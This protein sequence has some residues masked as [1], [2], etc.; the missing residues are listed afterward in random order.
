MVNLC[1]FTLHI[2]LNKWIMDKLSIVI[3]VYNEEQNVNPLYEQI[4]ESLTGFDYE[5]IFVDDGSKDTTV[6]V[7]KSIDDERVHVIEFKKNFGQSSAL[8]AG[9]DYATG[10]YIITMDGDLQ[11]D[12]SDIP[13]M[14]KTAKEGDY[15]LVTGIRK[16]RKDDLFIR[17]IPSIIANRLVSKAS[18]IKIKDNGCALKVFRADLA[19]SLGLYGELHRLISVLAALEGAK[20]AQ[21]DV[22]HHP[23]IHGQSK[24]G[25]SRTI[26]VLSD[27]TLLMFLKKYIQK[28]MHFF[29]SWGLIIFGS[30]MLINLYLFILKMMGN[31]IWGKPLLLLGI[32]LVLAG[33]QLI[34]IGI[35]SEILM[36]TYYESQQKRPFSI[37]N[38]FVGGKKR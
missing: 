29:G 22:K 15:D 35:I 27:L 11:N 9:F 28:P 13:F 31:D 38:I 18:N 24:Y 4:T 33:F 16:N 36:R 23:R 7:L 34:T 10:D 14:Y 1:C 12:P 21:V 19:K 26:K 25:L 3:S 6:Q 32:L 30:G 5:V 17:K 37:R 2:V 8:L 20:I